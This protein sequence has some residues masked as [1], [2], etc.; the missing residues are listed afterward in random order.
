M[1]PAISYLSQRGLEKPMPAL[2]WK[3]LGLLQTAGI[4]FPTPGQLS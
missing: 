2:V 3:T 1:G 4:V